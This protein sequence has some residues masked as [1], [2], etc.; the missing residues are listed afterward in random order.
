MSSNTPNN[1]PYLGV[2]YVIDDGPVPHVAA[3]HGE[4]VGT[5]KDELHKYRAGFS[6][7]DEMMAF[8]NAYVR[9]ML[10]SMCEKIEEQNIRPGT[11][12]SKILIET[13][14]K[15]ICHVVM[16]AHEQIQKIS[17]TNKMTQKL[18]NVLTKK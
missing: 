16:G 5:G 6:G 9:I 3:E 18:G 7:E 10:T 15:R 1:K 17:K 14:A 2:L 8:V 4:I 13:T 12:E 11:N